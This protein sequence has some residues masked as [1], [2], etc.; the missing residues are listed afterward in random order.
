MATLSPLITGIKDLFSF[1]FGGMWDGLVSG[2]NEACSFIGNAWDKT[3]SAISNAWNGAVDWTASLLGFGPSEDE[4]ATNEQAAN[5][6]QL[7]AQLKDMT[8]LNKMSEGFAERVAEMSAAYEPFKTSLAEGFE[9]I[10]TTM[11]AVAENIRGVVIPAITELVTS[12]SRVGTEIQAIAQAANLS[13]NVNGGATIGGASS[14]GGRNKSGGGW[15]AH[16]EGGI[17][18][19]PH[20]GVVA[21]AGREAVIPLEDFSRGTSLWLAA[22]RE[23]GLLSGNGESERVPLW[24]AASDDSGLL[25]PSMIT[26]N[27]NTNT[28]TT[29]NHARIAPVFNFTFNGNSQPEDKQSIMEMFREAWAEFQAQEMRVSFA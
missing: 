27:T 5:Q 20:F 18:S 6:A 28:S 4:I 29:D 15:W 25:A 19:Q 10:Y 21:E 11:T 26:N 13:V 22:G 9:T 3:T 7:Q 1:D 8:M 23:L 16:A 17:F 2:F 24:K 14:G 12:L